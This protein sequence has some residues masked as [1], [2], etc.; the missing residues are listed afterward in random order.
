MTVKG[1]LIE[2]LTEHG[3]S[4]LWN[5]IECGCPIDDLII[6]DG[7][8]GI[9]DCQP[10][11]KV[12]CN[13]ETSDSNFN[14]KIVSDQPGRWI[15]QFTPI[16]IACGKPSDFTVILPYGSKYEDDH[17]CAACIQ[18]FVDALIDDMRQKRNA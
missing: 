4:G 15:W 16:C 13:P 8:E 7:C 1:I 3:Y 9:E 5:D 10:G 11:Y 18:H 14:W 6:C 12:P 17:L 2:W